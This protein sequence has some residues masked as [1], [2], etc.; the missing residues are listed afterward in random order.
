MFPPAF[1]PR[2]GYL[3]KY[4]RVSGWNPVVVTEYIEDKTFA[5]LKNDVEVHFLKYYAKTGFAGK[6]A[7][8][9]TM[10]CD[11]FFDYKNRKIYKEALKQAEKHDFKLI[12]CSTYRAF[13]LSAARKLARRT[14]W[15][16]VVDL[17]DIIE[18]YA[19]NEFITHHIPSFFGFEKLIILFFRFL[20]LKERNKALVFAK[21]ITTVSPWHVEVLKQYNPN[22]ALIYNGYDSEFFY[23]ADIREDKFYI[24]YT[25]RLLSTEMRNPELLFQAVERLALEKMIDPELFKV[26]WFMDG[27][28]VSIIEKEVRKYPVIKDYMSYHGYMAANEIPRVL[29]SSAILL[30]LTNKADDKGPKGV[31]T[32]KFFEYLAVEKPVLCVR[33]DE[34][35]LEEVINKTK[36]GLSAHHVDE[37]Y[38]FIKQHFENWKSGKSIIN[39]SDKEEIRKFSREEQTRQFIEIFKR[40]TDNE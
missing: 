15:P 34:G 17:R 28:S 36:S 27:K 1:G 6:I 3:C 8:W 2:M 22:V 39:L 33:G 37:V 25:G 13:P 7:W 30:I 16:L 19:G 20:Y 24:T 12:L 32:T 38:D 5:F 35:C 9:W 31:M 4:L 21:A 29:N 26:R 14:G 18:Q 10:L 23:P 11:V 40:I